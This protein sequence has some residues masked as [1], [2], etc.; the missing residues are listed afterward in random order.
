MAAQLINHESSSKPVGINGH[1]LKKPFLIGVAGGTASG[2]VCLHFHSNIK[3]HLL[4]VL[5]L[6]S[7]LFVLRSWRNWVKMVSLIPTEE[8]IAFLRTVSIVN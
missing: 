2:K 5:I 1:G 6:F 7:Q 4:F 8:F 3:F